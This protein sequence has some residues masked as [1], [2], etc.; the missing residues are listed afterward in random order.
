MAADRR[1][2]HVRPPSKADVLVEIAGEIEKDYPLHATWLKNIAK[3]LDGPV[4]RAPY[5]RRM[6]DEV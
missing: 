1:K 2:T 3:D 6:S 5:D 4:G